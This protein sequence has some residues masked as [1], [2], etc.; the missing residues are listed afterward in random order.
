MTASIK[1]IAIGG[2]AGA[3]NALLTILPSLNRDYPIPILVVLHLPPHSTSSIA[4][5]FQRSCSI[6]VKEAEDKAPVEAAHVYF[7]PANYHLLVESDG[8]LSLSS[9][10]LVN[11]CRPSIDVLFESCADAYGEHVLGIVL[12]GANADGA[13][14]LNQIMDRG[15]MGI[16]QTPSSAHTSTMPQAACDLCPAAEVMDMQHIAAYLRELEIHP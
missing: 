5:L 3:M 15:G 1:A 4:E 6:A 16:V 11:Y 9:E 8:V 10:E 14:G 7:A 2:S 12:S 13:K